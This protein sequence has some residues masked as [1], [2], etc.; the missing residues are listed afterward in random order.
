MYDE[1]NIKLDKFSIG[2]DEVPY[3]AWQE[4]K[5][6]L[7]KY[8]KNLEI[9]DLYLNNLKRLVSMI[10]KGGATMT[11]WEDILLIQSSESQNEKNIRSEHFNYDPIPF[12]WNNTWREG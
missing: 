4:S 10:K 2:A 11:G 12:V 9:N 8:G 5:V 6:C 3:G 1:S 7:D